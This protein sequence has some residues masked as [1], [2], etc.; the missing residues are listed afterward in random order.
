[1]RSRWLLVAWIVVPALAAGCRQEANAAAAQALQA[2][3]ASRERRLAS[4]LADTEDAASSAPIAQWVLP[5]SLGEISGLA[6]MPDGR[7]LAHDDERSRVA[8]I[9]P[10]RGVL[11]KEFYA[12]NRETRGDFEGITVVGDV[13]YLLASKGQVYAFREGADHA[14]VRYVM[15][16]TRLGK[17][18][19][20][21][22]VVHDPVTNQLVLACK[23]VEGKDLDGH[24]VL[25]RVSLPLSPSSA[26]TRL[27]IPLEQMRRTHPWKALHPTDI[28]RDPATG[29]YVMVAALERALI[30]I[31]PDGVV[32]RA[33]PLPGVHLQAEGVALTRDGVLIIGDEG[34]ARPAT[35]TMYRWP[36]A[37]T[38]VE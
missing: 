1:M 2:E 27:A 13:V 23:R 5:S 18:C 35:I 16:D 15:T 32:V 26:I 4:R 22:G 36:V 6:L 3:L 14:D 7:L 11:L 10:R 21:E 9:D 31:T 34:R 25:Y 38:S 12:G 28:T 8:V 37:G 19:E 17:E 29:N 24:V 20:F 33:I 30:E